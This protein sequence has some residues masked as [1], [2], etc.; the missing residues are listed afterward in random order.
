MT[1]IEAINIIDAEIS[2]TV[3]GHKVVVVTRKYDGMSI[4]VASIAVI[5]KDNV[6]TPQTLVDMYNKIKN[7]SLDGM[8]VIGT[9]KEI[10]DLSFEVLTI[11]AE[12]TIGE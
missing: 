12:I 5:M 10:K 8:N 9:S 6:I 7:D 4:Y 11:E 1:E 2:K 3:S